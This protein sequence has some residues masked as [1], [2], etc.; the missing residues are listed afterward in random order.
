ML[1]YILLGALSYQ[2]ATGYQ[3]KQFMD[4]SARH[5]WYAQTSQ[6]YRTLKELEEAGLVESQMQAQEDRP[7]RRLYQL[8]PAG[9]AD[10]DAWLTTP[11]TAIEPAK[12]TLL[13]KLFFSARIDKTTLLTQLRLQR[14]LRQQQLELFRSEIVEQ[15]RRGLEQRPDLRRDALLW[16]CARR[17]GEMSETTYIAWLDE[18]IERIEREF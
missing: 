15:I 7:D 12:D 14:A 9:Q 6:I 16:D 5:F 4:N 2:P 17:V 18:T 1:K 11:M 3:L 10:L 13:A 8:T